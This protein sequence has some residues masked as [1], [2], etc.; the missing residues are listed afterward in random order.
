MTWCPARRALA[1]APFF[2]ERCRRAATQPARS[3]AWQL[4]G[5]KLVRVLVPV[6]GRNWPKVSETDRN[7]D[8]RQVHRIS[9]IIEWDRRL[10]LSAETDSQAGR[11][12]LD[13]GRPL[14]EKPFALQGVVQF[15]GRAVQR[16]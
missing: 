6:E 13:P 9:I 10:L 5:E 15:R 11:R 2:F 14:S 16:A 12:R 7:G 4:N 1:S 3:R 8:R